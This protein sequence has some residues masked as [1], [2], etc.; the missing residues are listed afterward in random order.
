MSVVAEKQILVSVEWSS[1]SLA[2]MRDDTATPTVTAEHT[3]V[4]EVTEWAS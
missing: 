1:S 3:R 2:A 4:N